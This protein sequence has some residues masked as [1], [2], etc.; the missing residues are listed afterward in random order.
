MF[1]FSDYIKKRDDN[2]LVNKSIAIFGL[3]LVGNIVLSILKK[4][5]IK[6]DYICDNNPHYKDKVIDNAKVIS[7]NELENLDK[8]NNNPTILQE[9]F[10]KIVSK[11]AG[12]F[13][14]QGQVSHT[15]LTKNID[16]IK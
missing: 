11:E 1:Q 12:C 9:E 3:G 13:Y 8:N 15:F 14:G 6:V 16:I 7:N 4:K 10:K 2:T 5:K